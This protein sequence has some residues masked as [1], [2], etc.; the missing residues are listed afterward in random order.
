MD[1]KLLIVIF[2][3]IFHLKNVLSILPFENNKEYSF[4]VE[5]EDKGFV[6]P[7]G[8][9]VARFFHGDMLVRKSD[10]DQLL[11]TLKNVSF[12]GHDNINELREPFK[13]KVVNNE[14]ASI[15]TMGNYTPNEI[16]LKYD[17]LEEFVKDYSNYTKYLDSKNWQNDHLIKLP[18]GDCQPNIF[19]NVFKKDIILTAKGT[20]ENCNLSDEIISS[21]PRSVD[22][23]QHLADDSEGGIKFVFDRKTLEIREIET[24]ADLEI[25]YEIRKSSVTVKTRLSYEFTGVSEVT[26]EII[27]GDEVE[28]HEFPKVMK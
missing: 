1:K 27:F 5:W 24:Y 9:K 22:I 7:V 23:E 21:V 18:M 28:V 6:S 14:I 25:F 16:E 11:I 10:D 4:K 26:E 19:I 20:K 3:Q 15:T 12:E 8:R 13:L 2:L 17:L